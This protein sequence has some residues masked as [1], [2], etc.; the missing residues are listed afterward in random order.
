MATTKDDAEMQTV[1]ARLPVA[2][3]AFIDEEA[4][5]L[6]EA[7]PGMEVNRSDVLRMLIKDCM[8]RRD[9]FRKRIMGAVRNGK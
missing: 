9:T 7:F 6:M 4:I 3:V 2:S 1:S 8:D 5:K